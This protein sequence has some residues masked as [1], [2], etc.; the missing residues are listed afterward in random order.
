MLI[1]IG[2]FATYHYGLEGNLMKSIHR[3][4]LAICKL[5]LLIIF[6]LLYSTV[7]ESK[8]KKD[9]EM[10]KKPDPDL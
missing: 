4:H 9:I 10:E 1:F 3:R 5:V 7:R 6:A 2:C 8:A